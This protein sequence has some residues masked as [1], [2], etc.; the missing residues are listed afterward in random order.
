M[1][2]VNAAPPVTNTDT[3]PTLAKPKKR[4]TLTYNTPSPETHTD[5]LIQHLVS[6]QD[7]DEQC[8]LSH[9]TWHSHSYVF[10]VMFGP[11]PSAQGINPSPCLCGVVWVLSPRINHHRLV[12]HSLISLRTFR[13][14]MMKMF[15]IGALKPS[16]SQRKERRCFL[17]R[18][19]SVEALFDDIFKM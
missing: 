1:F 19:E 13:L 4:E 3:A 9:I 11:L 15:E 10:T 16:S 14:K 8:W 6:P 5:T 7:H 2:G 18:L 12:L 17:S